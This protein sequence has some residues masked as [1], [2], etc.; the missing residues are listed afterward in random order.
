[1]EEML[2]GAGCGVWLHE[3][4]ASM[5]STQLVTAATSAACRC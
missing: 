5:S 3:P 1:M 4:R 2:A